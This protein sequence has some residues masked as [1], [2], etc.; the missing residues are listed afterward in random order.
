MEQ[1]RIETL[2]RLGNGVPQIHNVSVSELLGKK[3]LSQLV[4]VTGEL[5]VP[6][7]FLENLSNV[8]I[9][10]NTGEIRVY[11]SNGL[12][13]NAELTE[14][15]LKGGRLELI[16]NLEQYQTTAPYNSGYRL[17]PR[18]AGDFHFAPAPPYREI[19][20][21][22]A[23]T[24]LVLAFPGLLIYFWMRRRSAEQHALEL[25]AVAENL[26]ISEE[27]HRRS[28]ERYRRLFERNPH[29]MWVCNRDSLAFLAVNP[30]ALSRYGYSEKE[31][32]S[33]TVDDIQAPEEASSTP[34]LGPTL[35]A[36]PAL[37]GVSRHRR[38][39]GSFI[40][41]EVT[42]QPMDFGGKPE[43]LVLVEDVTDRK[44]MEE[45]LR[46]AHRLE[47]VGRLAGGIAHD[48]NNLLTVILGIGEM[49]SKDSDLSESHL[50]DIREINK[51]AST[52]A[53]LTSQLLAF[54]RRQIIVPQVLNLNTIIAEMERILRRTIG[55]DVRLMI[56]LEPALECVKVDRG[57]VEQ[58]L[59]NLVV[60]SRDA[61]P[62]GGNLLIQTSNSYVQVDPENQSALSRPGRYT[63]LTVRD[64]GIG[65]DQNTRRKMFEPFFT[66]KERGKGSGLGLST[67]YGIVKQNNGYIT[68]ETEAGAGT[69]IE[70]Y[71]PAA[72]Q[73]ESSIEI[74]GLEAC[75]SFRG[76]E[77]I[78]LV[79]DEDSVR[80]LAAKIL[81]REGYGV[82]EAPDGDSAL[83]LAENYR[84]PIA[85]LLTDV[86]MPGMSGQQL[87]KCIRATRP[88]TRVLYV[89]GYAKGYIDQ[90]GMVTSDSPFLQKPYTPE[91]LAQKVRSV[92]DDSTEAHTTAESSGV[93]LNRQTRALSSSGGEAPLLDE[94]AGRDRTKI[95]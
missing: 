67:V 28:E 44:K 46:Q 7:N 3:H 57:Q 34:P 74:S 89:S 25:S 30:A 5:I 37:S 12:R 73:H 90:A 40:D 53:A 38:K 31:F 11:L 29:P 62:D 59:L 33:M 19:A 72:P 84:A 32:L 9:R 60:N 51:A 4:R 87:A 24:V 1:L 16:G 93:F 61:M 92:L 23:L 26:R 15:V 64:G 8:R 55:E 86:V 81:Q 76:S 35:D 17:L 95:H 52:A 65:M 78:L 71:F 13:R 94:K 47:A 42:A 80:T 77:T 10:D 85:L 54:S 6:A 22:I 2:E 49:L 45:Q 48:F 18:T 70:I 50:E 82:L 83:A 66:T 20:L 21:T 69:K 88:K 75:S 91:R 68:V 36:H 56:Q 14:R 58:V 63:R 41:V 43:V 27:L 39:D 79:E